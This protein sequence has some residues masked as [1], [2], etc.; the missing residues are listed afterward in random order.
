METKEILKQLRKAKDLS[1]QEFCNKAD[2]SFSTYQNYETGKRIPTA[3]ILV[4]LA[5]F[6]EVTTDYLLGRDVDGLSSIDRIA[7]EFNMS[8]FEKKI[9]EGYVNLPKEMRSDLM[10]FL[11]KTVAETMEESSDTE[12]AT[13]D[14]GKLEDDA[15]TPQE[16]DAV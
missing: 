4:K 1:M 9:F 10:E 11:H 15:R 8:T 5:D 14:C 3:D 6:Y 7:T 12:I 2:I 16:K 13:T